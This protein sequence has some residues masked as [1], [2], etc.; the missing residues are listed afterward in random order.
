MAQINMN[1]RP[2]L[3]NDVYEL[4]RNGGHVTHI[5]NVKISRPPTAEIG[6]RIRT[7]I[8]RAISNVPVHKYVSGYS[9]PIT[10]RTSANS[11]SAYYHCDAGIFNDSAVKLH[12]KSMLRDLLS[13]L[14]AEFNNIFSQGI[15]GVSFLVTKPLTRQVALVDDDVHFVGPDK[16]I[17]NTNFVHLKCLFLFRPF[18]FRIPGIR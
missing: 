13:E 12:T 4:V 2:S 5:L 15:T 16:T 11:T 6:N 3:L 1:G 10:W 8:F 17:K 9:V 14:D 18:Y 7:A